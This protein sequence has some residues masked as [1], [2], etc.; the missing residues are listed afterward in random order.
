MRGSW[1]WCCTSPSLTTSN[2][3]LVKPLCPPIFFFRTRGKSKGTHF[4]LF[5]STVFGDLQM[6]RTT[7]PTAICCCQRPQIWLRNNNT[8]TFTNTKHQ[9]TH[10]SFRYLSY[11]GEKFASSGYDPNCYLLL[12]KAADLTDLRFRGTSDGFG[13][14]A[15]VGESYMDALLRID[16]N[17]Q[18]F[19]KLL[20]A[21]NRFFY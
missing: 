15:K 9:S 14:A 6:T 8:L 16:A 5:V 2:A 21:N 19:G 18:L 17:L 3:F 13:T 4:L 1:E 10:L 11:Q 12:S 20:W 7:T